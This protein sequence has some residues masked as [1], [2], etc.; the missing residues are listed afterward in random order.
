MWPPYCIAG[1]YIIV[2][3]SDKSSNPPLGSWI[4]VC[5]KF[6]T[7][8]RIIASQASSGLYVVSSLLGKAAQAVGMAPSEDVW[9]Q[10]RDQISAGSSQ[11]G[12]TEGRIGVAR[13]EILTKHL[14]KKCFQTS[15]HWRSWSQCMLV[16]L[17]N[18]AISNLCD[19]Y[20]P[21]TSHSKLW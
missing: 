2:L 20:P 16:P 5:L 15:Q 10:L 7:L 19:F 6:A 13:W 1:V 18:W 8:S 12:I 11:K 4:G 9:F 3:Y 17:E 21:K 14:Q